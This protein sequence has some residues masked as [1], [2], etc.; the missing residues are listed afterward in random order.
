M[1]LEIRER[2]LPGVGIRYEVDLTSERSVAVVIHNTGQR[3][4]Y[5]RED[6]D[7][8]YEKVFELSD[9]QARALGLLLVGAYYQPVASSAGDVSPTDQRVKWYQISP[10]SAT[11]N[12]PLSS[13]DIPNETGGAV[14]AVVRDGS[15]IV[16][17][18]GDFAL[19]AGDNVVVIGTQTQHDRTDELLTT[20]SSDP[21]P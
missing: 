10:D 19:K 12:E 5:R 16:D 1:P 7:G 9:S 8:D 2:T 15:R 4:L 14:L 21:S 20:V 11:L 6:R 3:D 18:D 17:P 13:V